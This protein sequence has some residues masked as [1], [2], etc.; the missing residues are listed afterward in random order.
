[1]S[2]IYAIN[3][4]H[5]NLTL[6]AGYIQIPRGG[7]IKIYAD[8]KVHPDFIDAERKGWL[9]YSEEEPTAVSVQAIKAI[10][11][12]EPNQG[13]T[14]EELQASNKQDALDKAENGESDTGA[15]SS[16]LGQGT[17]VTKEATT[18]QFGK[19]SEEVVEPVVEEKKPRGKK[20]AE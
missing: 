10:E 1:M 20:A 5:G 15:T 2:Q 18:T 13:M 4:S 17:L 12:F 9:A 7:F 14:A 16:L 8:E 19:D 11:F 6:K 3:T